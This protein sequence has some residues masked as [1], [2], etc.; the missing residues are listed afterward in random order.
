MTNAETLLAHN[1]SQTVIYQYKNRRTVALYKQAFIRIAGFVFS[2]SS[3]LNIKIIKFGE[4]YKNFFCS[5]KPDVIIQT[6]YDGLPNIIPIHNSNRV[7]DSET[8]WSLYS[9]NE[10]NAL[11]GSF[12]YRIALFDRD[13]KQ[14]EVYSGT[15]QLPTAPLDDPLQYPFGEV[16]MICLLSQGHGLMIHAC[17]IDD[18][19]KGFLFAG[20]STHGKTTTAKL[21][22]DHAVILNDDR[23][24]IRK[25]GDHFWMYGTPWH[26][27]Y[28]GVSPQGV[29][30]E[31]M[32]FL[33]HSESNSFEKITGARAASMLLA[34]S[35]PPLWD[36]EGMTFTLEFCAQLVSTVPCYRLNFK[37]DET[38]IDFVRCAR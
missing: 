23:I 20:N 4:S 22:K 25:K 2:I 11:V 15:K 24:V 26:G 14:V 10:R 17:G 3:N 1:G 27:D 34:R 30:I 7:F 38:I 13:V 35:F 6:K 18:S 8:I 16:L 5:D 33:Q 19:G 36:S 29:P 28:T 9:I 21:W 37:P 31:K 12:P 32:F